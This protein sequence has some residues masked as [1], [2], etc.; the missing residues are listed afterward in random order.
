LIFDEAQVSWV[1][2]RE[3]SFDFFC[4]SQWIF[5]QLWMG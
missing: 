3:I 2:G 4:S 5:Y 1:C